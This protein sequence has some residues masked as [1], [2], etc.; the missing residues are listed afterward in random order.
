MRL[1]PEQLCELQ[2]GDQMESAREIVAL[3]APG[4][5][6]LP[7]G[8]AREFFLSQRGHRP[9]ARE[10][11]HT[12]EL[13]LEVQGLQ[14]L[15]GLRQQRTGEAEQVFRRSLL[16]NQTDIRAPLPQIGGDRQQQGTAARNNNPLAADRKPSL[17]QGL[18]P[19]CAAD[20]GQRPAWKGQEPL[21]RAGSQNQ[22]SV[23]EMAD[24]F[25][26]LGHQLARFRLMRDSCAGDPRYAGA[27]ELFEPGRGLPHRGLRRFG[28][29]DLASQ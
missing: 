7:Q 23:A 11:R 24:P 21:A 15:A 5:A 29:P 14:Y 16:G 17:D 13:N 10:D 25:R 27:F 26:S 2:I 22:F 4:S 12:E 6:P 9:A 19:S 18:E 28:A 8:Y 3:H 20:I 1:A